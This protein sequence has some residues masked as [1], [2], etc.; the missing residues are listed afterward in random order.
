M[1]A[2]IAIAVFGAVSLVATACG[3]D[4]PGRFD[5][6]VTAVRDAVEAG[7]R[8]AALE[9]I[10]AL[11]Y[12]ALEAHAE[13]DVDDAELTQLDGLLSD[14]RILVDQRLPAPTTTTTTA[15]TTTAPPPPPPPDDDD[16]D[17]DEG[18]G[19]SKGKKG[20]RDD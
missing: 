15:T 18:R 7:D 8:D 9:A 19:N 14:A 3:D 17:E 6:D 10:D 12:G 1:R 16:D 4:G 5:A 20:E 13:G 2:R 11:T